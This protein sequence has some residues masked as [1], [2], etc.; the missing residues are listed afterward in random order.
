MQ[1]PL[2]D[3]KIKKR[4]R[5]DLGNVN[6]LAE[7]LKRYG[8]IQPI[9]INKKNVLISGRRRLEAAKILGWRTIN[10]QIIDATDE[11]AKLELELEENLQRQDL[12]D[13]EVQTALK[14][15]RKL[16]NPGF[17]RRIWMAISSFFRKLF[18]LD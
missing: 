8:Q 16:R 5:K 11:L 14:R 6:A 12:N 10:A 18:R 15:I 1:I 17:F 7:S 13:E 9:L 3:I 2:E 4:I